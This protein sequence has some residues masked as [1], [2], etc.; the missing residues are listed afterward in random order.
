MRRLKIAGYLDIETLEKR[1]RDSQDVM[2]SRHWQIL[3]LLAKGE[4]SEA[5]AQATG[6]SVKWIRQLAQ[7]YNAEGEAAVGDQRHH[8]R[9]AKSK[10]TAV[11]PLR[12]K[13]WLSEAAERGE[14]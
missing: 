14:P 4:P 2:A 10:L 5:V 1:Y 7:R 3:W 11:Q 8:N 9:G 6:Y 12:L 13:R